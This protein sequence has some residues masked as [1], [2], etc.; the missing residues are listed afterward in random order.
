MYLSSLVSLRIKF[1]LHYWAYCEIWLHYFLAL[2]S[3]SPATLNYCPPEL[4]AA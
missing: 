3:L 2:L 1:K 4:A